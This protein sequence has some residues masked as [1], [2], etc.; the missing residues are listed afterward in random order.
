MKNERSDAK[1]C[2]RLRAARKTAGYRSSFDFSKKFNIPKSTYSQ[3]ES[4]SRIPKDPA[5]KEYA[6]HLGVSFNWLRYGRGLAFGADDSERN[7]ALAKEIAFEPQ[8]INIELDEVLIT[9]VLTRVLDFAEKNGKLLSNYEI[10]KA[11]VAIYTTLT[12]STLAEPAQDEIIKVG[13]ETYFHFRNQNN[14]E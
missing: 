6:V 7:E 14:I 1:I 3:H 5:L 10:S 9:M 12:K 8:H 2:A 11:A 4:G 13:V